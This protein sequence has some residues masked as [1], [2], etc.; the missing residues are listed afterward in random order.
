[1]DKEVFVY[2]D[3][4]GTPQLVGRLWARMRKDRESATFEYDK[5]WLAHPER[6]SLEPALKLGPGPFHTPSDKPLFGAIG[7]SAPDRWGRVLMRRAERRR[8][9]REGQTPRTVREIDY[10]LMVD[11]EARQGALR[12]AEREGG[13]FLA[14]HGPTKIP[15]LIELPRLLSAAE[16]VL[17]DTDSDEDLRLLLAPGSSLGGA[18][19]KASVRDRDG[20]LLI[21]KFPNKGDEVN[22]VL[23]EAVALTLA[24][25][26]GIPV[27]A[28]RL[29]TVAER[30]VLLLRRFDREEGTRVPFLSAMSMLDAKDNEAHSYLEFVDILRQHGAAP[31]EDMHALWRRI[32]FSILISNTD[33]HLRNHGFLWPS[34][35]GWRLSPAYDLNPVP[36][37]IKP[38][39]LTTAID[40][41]DGTASLKLA[42]K[43][44]SYFELS[45]DEAHKIAGQVGQAV[46]TWRKQAAKL[47]LSLAEIDRTASAFEHED[48][49]AA[50]ALSPPARRIK[51]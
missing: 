7:D 41:D 33:D 42:L 51:K 32:V 5:D 38:R 50:Q 16:H 6:F 12:F 40:L 11:D 28:W 31:K 43:V 36:T 27:P 15:P 20:H 9:E 49:R 3:L 29:E 44:A 17:S 10:L 48:L 1:M 37:D 19:P 34:P 13:P 22:T 4:Q 46:A 24:A 8:A 2:V 47:G 39:I 21:A 35:A 30:P 26:A 25:K 18:R 23:W 14:E 45:E